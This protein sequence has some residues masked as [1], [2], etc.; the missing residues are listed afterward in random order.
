MNFSNTSYFFEKFI[1]VLF[2]LEDLKILNSWE[3]IKGAK[4]PVRKTWAKIFWRLGINSEKLLLK[5]LLNEIC[6]KY[7]VPHKKLPKAQ[8]KPYLKCP[9]KILSCTLILPNQTPHKIKPGIWVK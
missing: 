6:K 1:I 5:K 8:I 2:S 3:Q 9:T 4:T 7:K